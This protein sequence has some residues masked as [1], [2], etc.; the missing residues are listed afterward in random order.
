[1]EKS[2]ETSFGSASREVDGVGRLI[3]YA[4]MLTAYYS[5]VTEAFSAKEAPEA[6]STAITQIQNLFGGTRPA[7]VGREE[8]FLSAQVH[9]TKE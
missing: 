5:H 3:D 1:M 9:Q 2:L 7:F 6:P 8:A 4:D